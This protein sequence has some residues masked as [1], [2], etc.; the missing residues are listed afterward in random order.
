MSLNNKIIVLL[1]AIVLAT[2]CLHEPVDEEYFDDLSRV[3]GGQKP[4]PPVNLSMSIDNHI[5]TLQ[6]ET[7]TGVTYDPDTG[8]MKICIIWYIY[9]Q[10]IR[11]TSA[12][13]SCIT[14][15]GITWATLLK[16][17][18]KKALTQRLLP[19]EFLLPIMGRCMCG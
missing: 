11:R 1:L 18:L 15:S 9:Q 8:T 2:G 4:T 19:Y 10:L 12:T 14:I 5:I 6:F 3:K 13:Q 16:L 17:I 7:D